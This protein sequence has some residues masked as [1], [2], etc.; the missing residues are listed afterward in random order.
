[1]LTQDTVEHEHHWLNFEFEET[2]IKVDLSDI[3]LETL[4]SEVVA[5]LDQ[6]AQ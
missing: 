4:V 6:P 1:M 3:I 5:L 2:Q